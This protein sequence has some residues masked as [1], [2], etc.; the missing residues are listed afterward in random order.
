MTSQGPLAQFS[1]GAL[2][3]DVVQALLQTFG[4]N[5]A[6]AAD[7]GSVE[8]KTDLKAAGLLSAIIRRRLGRWLDRLR[9]LFR[10]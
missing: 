6:L 2:V 8:A 3:D 9:G 4:K 5:I 7:G 1:R 10:Q